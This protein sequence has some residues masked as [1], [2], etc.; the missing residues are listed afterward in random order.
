MALLR[1]DRELRLPTPI[2]L[3]NRARQ[4]LHGRR[5][6]DEYVELIGRRSITEELLRHESRN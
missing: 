4:R 1:A 2:A 3:M 6:V 5:M